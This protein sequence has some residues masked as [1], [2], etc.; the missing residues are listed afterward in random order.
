MWCWWRREEE[1]RDL[2]IYG[3]SSFSIVKLLN[4]DFLKLVLQTEM[5]GWYS[6]CP[7]TVGLD[8]GGIQ[9]FREMSKW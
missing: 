9:Y 3:P 6:I 2:K 7:V 5:S 4:H 8:F 1:G